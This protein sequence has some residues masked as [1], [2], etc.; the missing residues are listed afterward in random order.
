MAK[1]VCLF[2]CFLNLTVG[3]VSSQGIKS[4]YKQSILI[5]K[6]IRLHP[7]AGISQTIRMCKHD[8]SKLYVEQIKL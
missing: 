5:F 3:G 8:N 2:A 6:H 4:K 7:S 1:S